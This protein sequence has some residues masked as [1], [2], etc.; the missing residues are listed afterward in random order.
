MAGTIGTQHHLVGH[1]ASRTMPEGGYQRGNKLE[2]KKGKKIVGRV[3]KSIREKEDFWVASF[4]RKA[5]EEDKALGEGEKKSAR[6]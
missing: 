3:E 4:V 1:L 6:K 5:R 2:E